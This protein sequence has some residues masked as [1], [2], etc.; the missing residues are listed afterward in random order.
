MTTKIVVGVM[1]PGETASAEDM[2]IAFEV[3]KSIAGL[4]Y[5]VLTGGRDCGVMDAALKGARKEQGLTLGILPGE[6]EHGMSDALDI[7]VF[8]GMGNARNAINVLSS[9]VIVSIGEGPGTFS[10]IS[11]ALKTGKPVISFNLSGEAVKLFNQLGN[12]K[13]LP[14]DYFD[15]KVFKEFLVKAVNET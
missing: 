7:P 14:I 10:E 15:E 6:D 12:R 9:R 8:T 3:G 4:G 11:L 13:L 1:G 2:R 5:V